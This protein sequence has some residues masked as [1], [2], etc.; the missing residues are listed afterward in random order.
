M[1]RHFIDELSIF[2]SR[3]HKQLKNKSSTNQVAQNLNY[4]ESVANLY[5]VF[6]ESEG[7]CFHKV[8]PRIYFKNTVL[9]CWILR[10]LV[11]SEFDLFLKCRKHRALSNSYYP[12]DTK[13]N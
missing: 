3:V 8:L 6:G 1:I 9:R 2:Q 12:T 4:T 5:S 7:C 11:K 10:G 13:H